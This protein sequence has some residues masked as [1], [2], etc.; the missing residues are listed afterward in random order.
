S[1]ELNFLLLN[2]AQIVRRA[3]EEIF[4]FLL[5]VNKVFILRQS[6]GPF[7]LEVL[8]NPRKLQRE[9]KEKKVYT[10]FEYESFFKYVTDLNLHRKTAVSQAIQLVEKKGFKK[11]NGYDSMWL[12]MLVHLNNAWRHSD[13]QLIPRISLE[14]TKIKSLQWLYNNNLS[15]EDVKKIIFRLKCAPMI[16]SKPQVEKNFFCAPEVERPLAT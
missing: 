10:Y 2:N 14:G 5:F 4:Q 9:N 3:R 8:I 12:Y 6:R 16:V 7:Q 15:D 13:C 1:R 11:Y